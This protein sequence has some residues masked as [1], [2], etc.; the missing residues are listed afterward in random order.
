MTENRHTCQRNL[1][2]EAE[3][4]NMDLFFFFFF[5]ASGLFSLLDLCI[6]KLWQTC[7]G[8]QRRARAKLNWGMGLRFHVSQVPNSQEQ[9]CNKIVI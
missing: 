6:R 3:E 7:R 2:D 8:V 4:L 1:T 9:G 5:P